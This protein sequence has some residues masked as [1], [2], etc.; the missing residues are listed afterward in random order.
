MLIRQKKILWSGKFGS[1]RLSNV[2]LVSLIGGF[3]RTFNVLIS[4]VNLPETNS[5]SAFQ[6]YFVFLLF[7]IL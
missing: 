2:E 4:V 1:N 6:I 5:V 3:H 7:L